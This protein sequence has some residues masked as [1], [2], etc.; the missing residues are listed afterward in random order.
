MFII[1]C[2]Y[3]KLYFF[4]PL[5]VMEK[6]GH[7]EFIAASDLVRCHNLI[8]SFNSWNFI[9]FTENQVYPS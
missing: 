8:P 2:I 4:K 9:S 3:A 1:I 6:K 7:S 5:R